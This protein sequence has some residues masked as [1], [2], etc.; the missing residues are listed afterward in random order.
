MDAVFQM[1][2]PR[3]ARRWP[4]R[5]ERQ[6]GKDWPL[7]LPVN[8]ILVRRDGSPMFIG[9]SIA[10]LRDREGKASG[11]VIAF[12]DVSEARELEAQIVHASQHDSLT[13]LPNR[14]LLNDRLGQASRW[15][16]AGW[17]RP[18][19]CSWILTVQAYQRFAGTPDRRPA[20]S[21][22]CQTPAGMRTGAGH[23]EPT[24]RDEFVVCSGRAEAGRRG[25]HAGREC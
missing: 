17:D 20:A 16:D 4:I 14:V 7:R 13:G 1:L 12:R 5:W 25:H 19:C 8:A 9:S 11:A 23:G 18:R 22:D 6:P 24:G 10:P 3:Q 21:I 15:R 2:D